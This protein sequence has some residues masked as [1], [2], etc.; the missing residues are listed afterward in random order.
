MSYLFKKGSTEDET[1]SIKQIMRKHK[2]DSH[3]GVNAIEENFF[4]VKELKNL[5]IATH[6]FFII[7]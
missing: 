4:K 6:G 1:Q 5:H 2:V 3:E 7:K